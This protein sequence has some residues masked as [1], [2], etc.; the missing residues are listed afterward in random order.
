M[1]AYLLVALPHGGAFEEVRAFEDSVLSK[2]AFDPD[3]RILQVLFP[4]QLCHVRE[5][6]HLHD[7]CV[8]DHTVGR[9]RHPPHGQALINNAVK[10]PHYSILQLAA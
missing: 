8:L 4:F 2:L 9:D 1:P 7:A 3:H 6:I 10:Q 5:Q